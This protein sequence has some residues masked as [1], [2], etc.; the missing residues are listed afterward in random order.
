MID[1]RFVGA[2][3][4]GT[5]ESPTEQAGMLPT[6]GAAVPREGGA[7]LA[8]SSGIARA[9]GQPG[10]TEECDHFT[11]TPPPLV[12]GPWT[13]GAAPPAGYPKESSSCASSGTGGGLFDPGTQ[14][15]NQI[16]LELRIRTPTNA[17]SFSFDSNF[18]SYE[19]PDFICSAFN[20]FFVV[21]KEPLPENITDGNI[22]FD[23]NG[24]PIG[25]N[26][27]LLDVCVPGT[28]GGKTFACT[29]G[30]DLL[31]GTGFGA[32]EATCAENLLSGPQSGAATG[33][34]NTS[35][36]VAKGRIIKLRFA[37]W[38]TA[39][40]TLDSTVLVDNF[41]W[42]VEEPEIVETVPVI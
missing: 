39:D 41:V 19:Y 4:T 35:A 16:A 36:P 7:L 25:V 1:A 37:I 9:P 42:S 24:D 8:L 34:L 38:D 17:S 28:H 27:G 26:N 2:S 21:L 23:S 11:S 12:I 31:Q 15:F 30:T 18:Y 20:D 32:G 10:Y 6:F 33:W 29:Q 5:V 22:V 40:A 3:G 14:I 13:N